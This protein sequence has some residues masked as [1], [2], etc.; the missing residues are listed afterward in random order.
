MAED[1]AE[2]QKPTAAGEKAPQKTIN[3]KQQV[4]IEKV[5]DLM[6]L[7][8]GKPPARFEKEMEDRMTGEKRRAEVVGK[9]QGERLS[10]DEVMDQ[11]GGKSEEGGPPR[12]EPEKPEEAEEIPVVEGE[13]VGEEVE[14]PGGPRG[15]ER[16]RINPDE[17]AHPELKQR[18]AVWAKLPPEQFRDLEFLEREKNAVYDST[19]RTTPDPVPIEEAAELLIALDRLV[20]VRQREVEELQVEQHR[21][22]PRQYF[23]PKQRW[24]IVH[25]DKERERIFEE[26]FERADATPGREFSDAFSFYYD[27]PIYRAFIDILH[28]AGKRPEVTR[29]VT[30]RQLREILHNTNY[31]LIAQTPT[32]TLVNH[33]QHFRSEMA[34]MAFRKTG[35]VTALHMYEQALMQIMEEHGGWLPYKEVAW[36]SH[37]GI[38]T[39]RAEQ[40]ARQYLNNALAKK[41][42]KDENGDVVEKMEEWEKDRAIALAKGLGVVYMRTPVIAAS[43]KLPP[44]PYASIYAQKLVQD[45]APYVH[46]HAKFGIGKERLAVMAFLTNKKG[47]WW[48]GWSQREL[49][50]F[51]E[52]VEKGE[53]PEMM[54]EGDRYLSQSDPFKAANWLAGWRVDDKETSA[55]SNLEGEERKWL[56]TGIWIEKVRGDL[57]EKGKKEKVSD[58][59]VEAYPETEG[60]FRGMTKY[61]RAKTLVE[62]NI[63]KV[64]RVLPLKLYFNINEVREHVDQQMG[65]ATRDEKG[66]VIG[67]LIVLQEK[68]VQEGISRAVIAKTEGRLLP[69]EE[70]PELDFDSIEDPQMRKQVR[71]LA[72]Q[73]RSKFL[74]ADGGRLRNEFIENLE[75]KGHKVPFIF[76]TEDV[77][78]NRYEFIRTGGDSVPRRW[79]DQNNASKAGDLTIGGFERKMDS[80][81]KQEDIIHDL[82]E[83]YERISQYDEDRARQLIFGFAEGA[84][85]FYGKDWWARL[86]LGVGT[87]LGAITGYELL[88]LPGIK[89]IAD[90]VPFLKKINEKNLKSSFAKTKFGNL[91]LG[92]DETNKWKFTRL[93]E[94]SGML[95]YAQIEEF[96]KRTGATLGHMIMD[97]LRTWGPL[98]LF[99][100]IAE[101][102]NVTRKDIEKL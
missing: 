74:D 61:D 93:L 32:E 63:D 57:S 27:E 71:Q 62:E 26:L 88:K 50:E 7:T 15:G 20:A 17:V 24:D 67:E 95:T 48:Q 94:D 38:G 9:I 41:I 28:K 75:K 83:I 46:K 3:P 35:V 69:P 19:V 90:R 77:P 96:R 82:R 36:D 44:T 76:G 37:L 31:V 64:A 18:A 99:A 59:L 60:R 12:E 29:F 78:F 92:W 97:Q 58:E 1:Q 89:Q 45:I 21:G 33:L 56:G 52:R 68:A 84:M 42:V 2:V 34:D 98:G 25:D 51:T 16:P 100:I 10:K 65:F 13:I 85:K 14:E 70:E 40:L 11:A 5:H 39:G 102:I 87:T 30:E 73:I 8:G 101:F 91:A 79:N 23:T 53:L 55:L 66:K 72:E 43:S 22:R 49:L 80:Y 6:G 47:K 81:K 86:P 4:A 54:D